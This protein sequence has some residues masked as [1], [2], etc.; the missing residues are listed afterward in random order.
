[1]K[2]IIQRVQEL[3]GDPT[4]ESKGMRVIASLNFKPVTDTMTG[5]EFALTL[6]TI[7]A[8]GDK[9]M[10]ATSTDVRVD[11]TPGGKVYNASINDGVNITERLGG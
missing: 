2:T 10:K 9:H 7:I 6:A 3:K 5:E 11:D 4:I 1:M 8:Y